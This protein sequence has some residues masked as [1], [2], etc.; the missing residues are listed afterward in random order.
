[1]WRLEKLRAN[2]Q[3]WWIGFQ[4]KSGHVAAKSYQQSMFFLFLSFFPDFFPSLSSFS[5]FSS[6]ILPVTKCHCLRLH[7]RHAPDPARRRKGT[8]VVVYYWLSHLSDHIFIILAPFWSNKISKFLFQRVLSIDTSFVSSK[9]DLKNEFF[10]HLR[11]Y[12]IGQVVKLIG[13]FLTNSRF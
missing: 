6:S 4:S 12:Y 8:M 5:S 2:G 7:W 13:F 9:S 11:T 3:F 1:M 10:T